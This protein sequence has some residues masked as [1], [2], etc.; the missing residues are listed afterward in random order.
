MK[1]YISILYFLFIVINCFGQT[2][3]EYHNTGIS[4]AENY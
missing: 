3:E 2:A 4:K 1:K